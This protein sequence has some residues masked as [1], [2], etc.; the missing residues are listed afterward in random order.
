MAEKK[1]SEVVRCLSYA[2]EFQ[3]VALTRDNATV[4]TR[5]R[6]DRRPGGEVVV[7]EPLAAA[8]AAFVPTED[9]AAKWP[10]PK[11]SGNPIKFFHARCGGPAVLLRLTPLHAHCCLLSLRCTAWC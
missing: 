1:L 8:L 3:D 7:V 2:D 10:V 4:A 6:K 5:P 11:D 9:I